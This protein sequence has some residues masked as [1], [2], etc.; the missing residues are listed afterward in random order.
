[1]GNNNTGLLN[2]QSIEWGP[3]PPPP[4]FRQIVE[5]I[6]TALVKATG[7][8]SSPNT[9]V[10]L[11]PP[12]FQPTPIKSVPEPKQVNDSVNVT[13]NRLATNYNPVQLKGFS[14]NR[15]EILCVTDFE[16]AYRASASTRQ[17]G[18]NR[19]LLPVGEKLKVMLALARLRNYNIKQLM[20]TLREDKDAA[21]IIDDIEREYD[22]KIE[23]AID[24]IRA[25]TSLAVRLEKARDALNVRKSQAKISQKMASRLSF[26]SAPM[27][28][29][30]ILEELGFNRVNIADF[31]NTKI[32][33]Q[34]IN[35]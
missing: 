19:S 28:Y 29:V 1:M 16:P 2:T 14:E 10:S 17:L 31:S 21:K 25:L 15:P 6:H 23:N 33:M 22:T 8:G 7:A 3:V 35:D 18:N 13:R 27:G 12:P 9:T 11:S 20:E 5:A 24:D 26:T 30:D 32:L 4:P 34:I